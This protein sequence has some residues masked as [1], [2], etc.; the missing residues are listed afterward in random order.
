VTQSGGWMVKALGFDKEG[1]GSNPMLSMLWL[2]YQHHH[3]NGSS[4]NYLQSPQ[5]KKVK[6]HKFNATMFWTWS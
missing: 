6:N 2:W 3:V 1:E 4:N 5:K